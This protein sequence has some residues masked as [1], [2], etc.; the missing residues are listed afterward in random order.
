MGD[1]L[2][3]VSTGMNIA[4][5]ATGIAGDLINAFTY[6][7]RREHQEKREDNAVRRRAN[8]LEKAGFSKTLAAGSP[9]QAT[10]MQ[11]TPAPQGFGDS[12]KE[13]AKGLRES[14]S[15]EQQLL[16]QQSGIMYT[17]AQKELIDTQRRF[18][19]DKHSV[20]L[21]ILQNQADA[22]MFSGS[23][24][25]TKY[26]RDVLGLESDTVELGRK[27][28]QAEREG[29]ENK[30]FQERWKFYLDTGYD[31]YAQAGIF[32]QFNQ[33]ANLLRQGFQDTWESIVPNLKIPPE[34]KENIKNGAQ[35]L[36][37]NL[38]NKEGTTL[39]SANDAVANYVNEQLK[40]AGA[41]ISNLINPDDVA[42]R[43]LTNRGR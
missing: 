16:V 8:D 33:M 29:T 36:W 40:K 26:M 9:A 1:W 42:R 24:A 14:R 4:G 32:N 3:P 15:L 6:K 18:M 34:I 35:K 20:E 37:D 31:P 22:G 27:K 12:L 7:K 23:E 13:G 10:P 39:R 2:N 43:S 28:V 11:G 30:V 17:N 25:Y 19:L 38:L 21:K 41:G 5:A